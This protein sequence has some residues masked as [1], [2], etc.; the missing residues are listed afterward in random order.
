MLVAV[1][2]LQPDTDMQPVLDALASLHP[3]PIATLSPAEARRQPTPAAAVKKVLA[4][5]GRDTTPPALVPG[6]TSVDR[7]VQ[8]AEGKLPARIYT[9][10]GVD[11]FP[12]I[13]YYHGGEWVIA[14]KNVYDGGARHILAVDPAREAH[15]GLRTHETLIQFSHG[16]AK[17]VVA[18]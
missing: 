18:A 11:P 15:F 13:V 3:K 9:P 16:H 7:S 12:V 6:V 10:S 5:E 2:P 17:L 8:G 1:A 14:D 4:A